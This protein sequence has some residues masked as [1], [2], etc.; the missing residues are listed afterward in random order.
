MQEQLTTINK[1]VAR[2]SLG[3]AGR[4]VFLHAGREKGGT[5]RQG[6]GAGRHPS[7]AAEVDVGA[8]VGQGLLNVVELADGTVD[9][10]ERAALG[11]LEDQVEVVG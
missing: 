10:K 3:V 8:E 11:G 1:A 7:R 6:R 9:I 2:L 4:Q 5:G